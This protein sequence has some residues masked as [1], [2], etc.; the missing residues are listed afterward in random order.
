MM[1]YTSTTSP[2]EGGRKRCL[3]KK[4][5]C[6]NVVINNIEITKEAMNS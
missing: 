1:V 5:I 3:V 6:D 4:G 2:K